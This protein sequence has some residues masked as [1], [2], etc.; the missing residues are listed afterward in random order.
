[1]STMDD[2]AEE[3]MQEEEQQAEHAEQF[4]EAA[5]AA[6]EADRLM[7]EQAQR[8]ISVEG[9]SWDDAD[10]PIDELHRTVVK[11]IGEVVWEW[12]VPDGIDSGGPMTREYGDAVVKWL[13]GKYYYLQTNDFGHTLFPL[14]QYDSHD[15]AVMAG[16]RHSLYTEDERESLDEQARED[17]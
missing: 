4:D 1:M 13:D 5:A 6:A 7:A 11:R 9:A 14:G 8:S 16:K 10:A 2:S 12:Y 3:A 15:A 17:W